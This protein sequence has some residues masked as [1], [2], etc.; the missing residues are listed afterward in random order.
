MAT[1]ETAGSEILRV[2]GRFLGLYEIAQN[3]AWDNPATAGSDPEAQELLRLME[4]C[5]W[6]KGWAYCAAFCEA[7]W[8]SAYA[9]LFAPA[10]L[11]GEIAAKLTPSVMQSFH[12]WGARVTQVPV[13]GA[14][15]FMQMGQSGNGHCGIVV[16]SDGGRISTIEGNTS[17]DPANAALDREGD[18]I[19]RRTRTL[20]FA[21]RDQGLWLRGFLP[22]IPF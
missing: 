2:A 13:P 12:N 21:P 20:S 1:S 17:P 14:I 18:G 4:Q 10:P 8:R 16:R 22:P 3:S 7:V 11:A 19:F 15:Y 9:N 6:Q 5:G